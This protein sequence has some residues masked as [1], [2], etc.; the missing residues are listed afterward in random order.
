M[1]EVLF[2]NADPNLPLKDVDSYELRLADAV[3]LG[4]PKQN[5]H[6]VLENH[7]YWDEMRAAIV[8]E[9]TWLER[10]SNYE[11]AEKR[12]RERRAALVERGY[13]YSDLEI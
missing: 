10:F 3:D 11:L 2:K 8:T 4:F 1:L 5:G 7:F 6:Y 12:Y 13:V 9:E